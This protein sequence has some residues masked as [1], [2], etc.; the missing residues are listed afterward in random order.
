MARK[1]FLINPI[2]KYTFSMGNAGNQ[3]KHFIE[4]LRYDMWLT[5]LEPHQMRS[6]QTYLTLTPLMRT[7]HFAGTR[8]FSED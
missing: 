2:V 4:H 6:L 1:E 3:E 8:A 7:K 5:L